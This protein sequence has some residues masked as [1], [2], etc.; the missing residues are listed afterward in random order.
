V[1]IFQ[2]I[3]DNVPSIIDLKFVKAIAQD[4]QSYLIEKFEI[5]TVKGTEKCAFYLTED[6]VV[7]RKREELLGQEKRLVEVQRKLEEF[8]MTT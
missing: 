1:C 2:R 7:R 5:G 6:K 3:I 8:A 4:V